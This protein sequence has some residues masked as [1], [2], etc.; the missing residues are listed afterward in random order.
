M[1]PGSVSASRCGRVEVAMGWGLAGRRA[2]EAGEPQGP[3]LL[4][5]EKQPP[6]QACPR[7]ELVGW[8]G[9]LS[10]V[11]PTAWWGRDMAP[12]D[13]NTCLCHLLPAQSVG[14]DT[15]TA[16]ASVTT[17]PTPTWLRRR[18]RTR[19]TRSHPP[20]FPRGPRSRNVSRGVRSGA[21]RHRPGYEKPSFRGC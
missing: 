9:C 18:A 4:T 7:T 3:M 5:K 1:G 13:P 21:S 8:G 2:M 12:S 17:T 6:L 16:Q 11:E 14:N 10:Q 15:R 19:K 20:R